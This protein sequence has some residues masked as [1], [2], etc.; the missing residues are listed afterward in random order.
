MHRPGIDPE[1]DPDAEGAD[2]VQA[3]QQADTARAEMQS[4]LP[5]HG[6]HRG[7]WPAE[8]IIND[9]YD[10]RAD[11]LWVIPH[12]Q[13]ALDNPLQYAASRG[14]RLATAMPQPEHRDKRDQIAENAD[15]ERAG[16]PDPGE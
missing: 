11:Q 7:E 6:D 5:D 13:D 16:N 14:G 8:D 9:G 4:V 15:G 1:Q 3:R 2:A 12:H 10:Q